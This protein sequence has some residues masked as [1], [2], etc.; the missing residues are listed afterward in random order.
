MKVFSLNS[1]AKIPAV[2]LG[3]WT[4]EEPEM[5]KA[6]NAAVDAGYRHIDCSPIY[7]NEAAIGNVFT[8][9]FQ[10]GKVTRDALW[11]TSKLWNSFHLPED[12]LPACEKTLKDLQLDYLDLFLI[13][14]PVAFKPEVAYS[15]P[16]SA[17][18][19]LSLDE[20]PIEKTWAA[21]EA[22]VDRGLVKSIGVSNF[23]ITHLKSLLK[24]ARIKP[25]TNQVEC[26]PYLAQEALNEFCLE[27]GIHLTAYSPLGSGGR[28]DR[29]RRDSD[30]VLLEHEVIR[31]IADKHGVTPA[32]VA[33]AWLLQREIIV[34]PKSTNPE[35]IQTNFKAQEV[36]LS[37]EEIR[38]LSALDIAYHFIYPSSWEFEGGSFRVEDVWK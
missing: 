23:S 8:N 9:L 19:M 20:A 11:I 3:T 37:L 25:V 14:W 16:T 5:D 38:E 10:S 1:G 21:M 28:P 6:I 18:D 15:M 35:R 34:I 17:D 32:E 22:L 2:G 36:T 33:L 7:G 27:H 24:T 4:A 12:V 30:P 31:S 13:H 29:L 26:H